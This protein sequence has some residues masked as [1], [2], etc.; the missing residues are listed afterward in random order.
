MLARV[1]VAGFV[2]ATVLLSGCAS[3]ATSGAGP[4]PP[5]VEPGTLRISVCRDML[6]SLVIIA[7]EQGLFAEHGLDAVVKYPWGTPE[8]LK[9]LHA[10]EADVVCGADTSFVIESFTHPELR[11][12]ATL[13][14]NE[15][16]W[17][18]LARANEVPTPEDLRGKRVG[19]VFA[20]PVHFHLHDY[21]LSH[22]LSERD[23]KIVYG[24][25]DELVEGFSSGELDAV[26][27][28]APELKRVR[29][30]IGGDGLNVFLTKAISTRTQNMISTEQLLTEKPGQFAAFVAALLDA[31][32]YLKEHPD[33][34]WAIIGERLQAD[35]AE[36]RRQAEK[37]SL[38]VALEQPTILDLEAQGDWA[39]EYVLEKGSAPDYLEL[40]EDA[41]LA[42]VAPDR[43]MLIH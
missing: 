17:G 4:T 24:T 13:G 43:I 11:L 39:E 5:A 7:D 18:V 8:A 33:Q 19:V 15:D 38:R 10:G 23:V 2:S 42:A 28:R 21:L 35:P 30:E 6:S 41:P 16:S 36:L 1:L 31:E 9:S 37:A 22:G 3:E 27:F 25:R 14:S 20:G 26:A 32:T 34:A 12:V 40:V 29:R